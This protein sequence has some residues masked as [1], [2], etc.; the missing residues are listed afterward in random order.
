MAFFTFQSFFGFSLFILIFLKGYFPPL[1][2]IYCFQKVHCNYWLIC[3][4]KILYW[5]GRI[6]SIVFSLLGGKFERERFNITEDVHW[7]IYVIYRIM[8]SKKAVES[9]LLHSFGL[10]KVLACSSASM[11]LFSWTSHLSYS[12][13]FWIFS[14]SS[15][16]TLTNLILISYTIFALFHYWEYLWLSLC[17][18]QLRLVCGF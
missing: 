8:D 9:F 3:L 5:Q 15:L 14:H 12:L 4:S 1:H 6:Y 17:L 18:N 16:P 10:V 2:L 13:F 7:W 11:I